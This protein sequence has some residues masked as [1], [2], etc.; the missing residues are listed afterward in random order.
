MLFH[1]S[2]SDSK[3]C[4][5]SRTFLSIL[6]DLYNV[7]VWIVSTCSLISKPSSPLLILLRNV[8]SAPITTGITAT[9]MFRGFF[10]LC[11]PSK[12]GILISLFF[13]FLLSHCSTGS[14]SFFL[15]FFFFFFCFCLLSI[16]LVVW[17]RSSDP[18]VSQNPREVCAS[19]SAERIPN[20]TNTLI[21][22][23]I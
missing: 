21:R 1:W 19:Y 16:G 12:V 10:F 8:P 6:T 22:M 11:F 9:F 15:S 14:L 18:F 13:L 23:K 17:P 5:V 4:Q 7:V 3:S 20:C 2:L